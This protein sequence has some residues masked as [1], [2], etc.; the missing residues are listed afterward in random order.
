MTA[1][2]ARYG[3]RGGG[4]VDKGFAPGEGVADIAR[5]R[6][7]HAARV[8]RDPKA[9]PWPDLQKLETLWRPTTEDEWEGRARMAMARQ[10][11]GVELDSIDQQALARFPD[12]PSVW[13]PDEE[14]A[15]S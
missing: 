4:W 13:F 1:A 11:A 3:R 6:R 15:G 2:D 9:K 14:A 5:I 12:P 7:A 10:A 8:K